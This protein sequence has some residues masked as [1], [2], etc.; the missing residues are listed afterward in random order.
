MT[1]ADSVVAV[2]F[3]AALAASC[4]DRAGAATDGAVGTAGRTD[5]AVTTAFEKADAGLR[6]PRRRRRAAVEAHPS[7]LSETRRP[8]RVDRRPQAAPQMDELIGALQAADREGLDPALYNVADAHRAP[9]GSGPR[10]PHDERLRRE[11]GGRPGRLAHLP[12]SALRLGSDQRPRGPVARAIRNGSFATRRR[13][14]ARSSRRRSKS[15]R[16]AQSLEE[17]TP[18]H[19]QYTGLRDALAKYREIA[20]RGGWPSVAGR[21]QAEARPAPSRRA[22]SLAKRLAVTGDYT[23]T[24]DEQESDVR[25]RTAGSGE[26][27]SA[28]SRARTRRRRRP[29][30]R[31][32]D[33]RARRTRGCSQIALNLERWRWLPRDLGERH[34]LVNVPEYRLEVWEGRKRPALDARRRR[35]EGHAD[36]DLR[37]R[38]DLHRLLALLERAARDRQER[39]A[40]VGAARSGVSAAHEHGSARQERQPG[41]PVV[42]R[43]RGRRPA[44]ASASARA[45]RTR[46][47]S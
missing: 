35:Q 32:A 15:N 10:V 14:P 9:A 38:H 7:V 30:R 31:G 2:M 16:V 13:I 39:D 3:A 20:Q 5:A 22:V 26:A 46:S 27:V 25:T 44:T 6:R 23:G 37:R 43:H 8:L 29:R 47:G 34:I 17:L 45:R 33:E 11:R 28:A 41:R 19:P 1:I 42:D 12:L 21:S 40:A 18:A 4:G 24:V 36:A